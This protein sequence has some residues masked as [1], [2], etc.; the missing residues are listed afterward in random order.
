MSQ[1][2]HDS[3]PDALRSVRTRPLFVMRLD[4]QPLQI[5]GATPGPFRRVAAVPG[6]V[7]EGGRL[8][9]E[10]LGGGSDWQAVRSDGSTTLDVRLVLKTGD[11]VLVGM[12][13]RGL[14]HGPADVMKRIDQ[15]EV[16]D[17]AGYYFRIAPM[18]EAPVGKYD[19]LN[20]IVAVGIGDRR[21]AGPVYSVFEVL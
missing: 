20:R 5:V 19:W 4:V 12:T 1:T 8:S 13:Y 3:L 18:F 9:G 17:P 11:G 16:V 6:G 14:R 10:V 15:G 7:F 21:P 2:S